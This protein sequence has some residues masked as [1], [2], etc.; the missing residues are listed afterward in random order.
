M[1]RIW[2][3]VALTLLLVAATALGGAWYT[4]GRLEGVLRASLEQG[5]ERLRGALP[6]L[7]LRLELLDVERGLLSSR[8]RYRV[9]FGAP[10]EVREQVIVDRIEHGPLPLSRLR[11]LRWVPVMAVSH[12]S[13][14]DDP[15]ALSGSASIGYGGAV[16]GELRLA[17]VQAVISGH[18]LDLSALKA[19]FKR[20]SDGAI[21]FAAR[22][23]RLDLALGG[24]QP[25]RLEL[26]GVTLLSDRYL[27]TAGLYLGDSR[28]VVDQAQLA[29]GGR[30]TLRLSELV[31]TDQLQEEGGKVAG[32][33]AYSVGMLTVDERPFGSVHM[34]WRTQGLDPDALK[35]L[36]ELYREHA[37]HSRGADSTLG[38]PERARLQQ[39]VGQLLAGRPQLA[40]HELWL[41][42]ANGEG[43]LS[44]AVQL[45]KPQSLDLPLEQ[46]LEQSID[47][48]TMRMQVAKPLISDLILFQDAGQPGADPQ[49]AAA[50]ARSAAE[51][52]AELLTVTGLARVEGEDVLSDLNYSDNQLLLNGHLLPVEQFLALLLAAVQ[53]NLATAQPLPPATP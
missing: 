50:Q 45:S 37:L 34:D 52:G 7:E 42:T 1:N 18:A 35:T 4:G 10:G 36:G 38:E 46:L 8:A 14:E 27:G 40:L 3:A 29:L 39:A 17:P 32:Q 53:M 6:G 49:A 26:A 43:R 24:S 5:G 23:Q 22:A 28:L 31:Q 44:L 19:D 15:S 2:I 21:R 30:P 51:M 16:D 25:G 11:A 41:R 47:T 12:F 13:L 9:R 33:F 48:L 20:G